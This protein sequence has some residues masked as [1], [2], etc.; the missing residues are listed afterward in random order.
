MGVIFTTFL[1]CFAGYVVK[2]VVSWKERLGYWLGMGGILAV[3][4]VPTAFLLMPLNKNMW[5]L[6]YQFLTGSMAFVC[7]S[8]CYLLVDIMPER[9]LPRITIFV[10][11]FFLPAKWMGMNPLFIFLLATT[12][13]PF[14]LIWGPLKSGM[15]EKSGRFCLLFFN[16]CFGLLLLGI[17]IK[18]NGFGRCREGGGG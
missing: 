18:L 14:W 3:L 8:L 2:N 10:R 11:Y 1:G 13:I 4:T 17:F 7:L 5:S 6:S 9:V 15:G 16:C 12:N